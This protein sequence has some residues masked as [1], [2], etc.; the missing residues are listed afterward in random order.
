MATKHKYHALAVVPPRFPRLEDD[1]G[2]KVWDSCVFPK[3]T[4]PPREPLVVIA[5][6]GSECISRWQRW[7][8]G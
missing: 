3:A 7:G 6:F 4:F 5:N 1:G 2:A 8:G